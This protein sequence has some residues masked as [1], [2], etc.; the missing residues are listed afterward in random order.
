MI[1]VSVPDGSARS[2][3]RGRMGA[4]DSRASEKAPVAIG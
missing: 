4:P 2:A 1:T 3:I